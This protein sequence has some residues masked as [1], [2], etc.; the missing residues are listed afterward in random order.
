MSESA[1]LNQVQDLSAAFA[2][3]VGS[4]SYYGG[5]PTDID[6][7]DVTT[8]ADAV[9]LTYWTRG[10]PDAASTPVNQRVPITWTD[11]HF[12]GRRPWFVCSVYSDGQYCGRRVAVL[13][14]AGN[15]F[16][17]RHC[18]GLA[19]ETQ[20]QSAGWRGV[21]KSTK[22]SNASGR[23]YKPSGAIPGKATAYALADL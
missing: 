23:E 9:M 17:C 8:E 2:R 22:N 16:A 10:G 20:Q 1:P 3:L 7:I 12:G 13:Y 21:H 11:C 5:E 19:Y 18:Y 4:W 6:T 14:D 15:Y